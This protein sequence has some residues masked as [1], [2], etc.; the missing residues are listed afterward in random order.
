MDG[1]VDEIDLGMDAGGGDVAVMD[2]Q[3]EVSSD[4]QSDNYGE[5]QERM[6]GDDSPWYS[7]SEGK[8]VTADGEVVVDPKT[9]LPF[10]SMDEFQK[11][12][13]LQPKQDTAKPKTEQ[14]QAQ[15]TKP[16]C[17]AFDALMGVTDGILPP[18]KMYALGKAGIDYKYADELVPKANPQAPGAA[19]HQEVDPIQRV[20][21]DRA[22][23]EQA[24]ISPLQKVRDVLVAQGADAN[25]VDN[26]LSPILREQ[27]SK[28]E[29]HYQAAYEKALEER[30][31][32]KFS[33]TLTQIER[34][35]ISAAANAN[36]SQ[37][38]AKYYPDG[39]K[40]AFF[41]LVNGHYGEDGAFVRGPSAQVVDLL[42]SVG[43]EGKQF[44]DDQARN[45][46]YKDMFERVM[47]DPAKSKA[48][49]DVAHYY[50]LGKQAH[51]AQALT[52]EKGRAAAQAQQSRI[53]KTIKTT[54]GSFSAPRV[55]DDEGSMP[56]IL[57]SALRGSR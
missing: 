39:G 25:A 2:G 41:S 3:P 17:K 31:T 11:W 45:N 9:G 55:D 44:P 23:I 33:P 51:K 21:D 8:V 29:S 28:V 37:L 10:R 7:P 18:E 46:A 53:Q 5:L 27:M 24:T 14:E 1:D 36:I 38:S 30:M 52:F 42:V 6:A 32:S 13:A 12:D 43:S 49:V 54:P 15:T 22:T 34:D 57:R 56:D 50:W 47:A 19:Q 40:D 20:K 26:L 35:K 48:L 16:M 4:P